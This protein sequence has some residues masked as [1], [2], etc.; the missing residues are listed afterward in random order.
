MPQ[1]PLDISEQEIR[2]R[3]GPLLEGAIQEAT[4][5]RHNYIGTEHLFNAMTRLPNSVTAQLLVEAGL[6]PRLIRNLIRREVGAGDDAVSEWPPLTPRAHRVLAMAVYL[7]DDADERQV[8][9]PHVLIAMLQEGEGVAARVL[10]RQG[11]D[12][13]AWIERLL[14]E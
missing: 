4:R 1:S 13:S 2:K 9:E 10:A 6:E 12:L 11:I 3:C 7:A 8:S 5:L 14:V